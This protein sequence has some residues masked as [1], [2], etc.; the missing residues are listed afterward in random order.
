MCWHLKRRLM[1]EYNTSASVYDQ[2]YG[3]EQTAKHVEGLR[4]TPLPSNSIVLDAG[5]GSGLLIERLKGLVDLDVGLDFSKRMVKMAQS[6]IKLKKAEFIIGDVENMPLKNNAFDTVFMFTVLNNIPEPLQA[7]YEARRVLKDR[8]YLIVSF[9]KKTFTRETAE[10]LL[11]E[12]GFEVV[13]RSS[14]KTNDYIYTC[15][16]KSFYSTPQ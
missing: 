12:S 13:D 8:G 10:T 11:N 4:M 6:K 1:E 14:D 7:L 15:S 2:L 16:K 9:L 3:E 5:C